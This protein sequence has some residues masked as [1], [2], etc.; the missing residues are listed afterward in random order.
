MSVALLLSRSDVLDRAEITVM[1]CD[2]VY[3]VV[4]LLAGMM[5]RQSLSR[6]RCMPPG[7]GSTYH[8]GPTGLQPLNCMISKVRYVI[9]QFPCKLGVMF[10]SEHRYM[11]LS[12]ISHSDIGDQASWS[13]LQAGR[14]SR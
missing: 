6:G 2:L 14:S 4:A 12:F 9:E 11:I 3:S 13:A 5:K 1:A 10:G 7:L 8:P